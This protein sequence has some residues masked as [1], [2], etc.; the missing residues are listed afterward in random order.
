[1]VVEEPERCFRVCKVGRK[2]G[3]V[4]GLDVAA[5]ADLTGGLNGQKFLSAVG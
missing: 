2:H 4:E 1:M 3:T 5:P